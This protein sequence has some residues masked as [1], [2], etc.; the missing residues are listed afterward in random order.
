MQEIMESAHRRAARVASDNDAESSMR[1]SDESLSE[2]E[3]ED[4]RERPQPDSSIPAAADNAQHFKCEPKY[5]PPG[6]FIGLKGEN[7]EWDQR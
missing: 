4:V 5:R 3:V 2:S 7:V 1:Q 6:R